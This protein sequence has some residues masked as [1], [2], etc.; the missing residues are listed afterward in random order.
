[1]LSELE[2]FDW[3]E[4]R[5]QG[6]SNERYLREPAP[7]LD[8]WAK[9]LA[10]IRPPI[11]RRYYVPG[12]KSETLTA[13]V[14]HVLDVHGVQHAISH[15]AAAQRYA[16]FLSNVSQVRVRALIGA[17]AD[18]AIGDL[19]ASVVN[20]G[21]NLGLIDAKSSNELLARKQIEGLWLDSPI[22]IYLDL[23]HGEGRSKETAEHFRKEGIGF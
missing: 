18:A 3:L 7:L 2:R 8:A 9:Q 22:Q 12:A 19:E 20:D 21:A 1:M 14:G 23:L 13:R 16:P 17:N 5:G 4:V 6:P 10:T 15:E 11:L